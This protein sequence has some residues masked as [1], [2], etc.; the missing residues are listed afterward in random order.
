MALRN[1]LQFW[2]D[3]YS[4]SGEPVGRF[5]APDLGYRTERSGG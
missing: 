5:R 4:S 2:S 3:S 1:V